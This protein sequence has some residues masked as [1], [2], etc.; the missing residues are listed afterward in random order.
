MVLNIPLWLRSFHRKPCWPN[1][2]V[3]G[4]HVNR[5]GKFGHRVHDWMACAKWISADALGHSVV[6]VHAD[7]EW[8]L[9]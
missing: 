7:Q 9:R 3:G 6:P 1:A 4:L 2:I 8:Q 5:R